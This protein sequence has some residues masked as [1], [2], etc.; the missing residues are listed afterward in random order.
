VTQLELSS[1]GAFRTGSGA[2]AGTH[3]LG[4]RKSRR[5]TI[6]AACIVTMILAGLVLH[7]SQVF[8]PPA[9]K[10]REVSLDSGPIVSAIST[11]GTVKPLAAILVGSQASGQ[12]KELA[13]DFN[14]R[15]VRGD[16]IARLDD[17]TVRARLDQAVIEVDVASAGVDIQRAQLER[18][19][20]DADGARAALAAARAE[21]ERAEM[22]VREA[23]RDRDRKRELFARGVS[24]TAERDRVDIAY[25]GAL[26]SLAAARARELVAVSAEAS[27]QASIRIAAAQVESA[28]AQVRQREAT[29]HQLRIDVEHTV[30]RTPI[31]GIVIER[32]V[33]IGQTVAASLQAPTI[34]TIAPDL[35][36]MQV[37]ANVDEADIGRVT[38]GQEVAFTVDA[39]PGRSFQGGVVDIHKMP[40][41]TQNVVTYTVVISVDNEDLLLMPGMTANA[42]ILVHKSDQVLRVPNRAALPSRWSSR[43][44]GFLRGE[45]ASAGVSPARCFGSRRPPGRAASRCRRRNA[46]T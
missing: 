39:F 44:A 15:V 34:F 27:N 4:S 13:A 23:E 10:Y 45:R 8:A 30:I 29:V 41:T 17:D 6:V 2:A 35:R 16:V 28:V 43:A 36:A 11:A 9:V 42:R 20:A 33:D 18:A 46:V 24:S 26:A 40:Q 37:H 25:E 1:I 3:D 38:I 14:S 31:D 5:A 21:V 22:T 32:S 12:I 7:R 19:R